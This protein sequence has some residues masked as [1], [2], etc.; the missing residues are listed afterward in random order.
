MTKSSNDPGSVAG[1]TFSLTLRSPATLWGGKSLSFQKSPL[2]NDYL[3]KSAIAF[4]ED[5]GYRVVSASVQY[6]GNN[7]VSSLTLK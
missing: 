5:L 3:L 4:A 6:D 7:E 1:S 2:K